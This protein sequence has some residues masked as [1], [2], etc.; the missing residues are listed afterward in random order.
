MAVTAGWDNPQQTRII[1]TF[2]RP[3]TWAEFDTAYAQMDKL[4]RSVPSK[5]D[6][7]LDISDGGLPPGNAMQNFK[8]VSENQHRNLGKIVVV[9]LPG[10]FRGI[11][12]IIKNVYRGRYESPNYYFAPTLEKA[13]DMLNQSTIETV[14]ASK[15]SIPVPDEPA[16]KDKAGTGN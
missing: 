6:L 14:E 15:V 8:R 7:V 5:V 9:G 2:N 10:F 1:V 4:F 11:L 13:R 12:N 3:W 16:N